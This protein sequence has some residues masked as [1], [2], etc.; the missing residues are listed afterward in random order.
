[1]VEGPWGPRLAGEACGPGLLVDFSPAW[2]DKFV[3]A[4]VGLANAQ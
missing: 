1:M 4:N 3:C 2:L